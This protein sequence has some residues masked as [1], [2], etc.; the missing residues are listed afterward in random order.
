MK[1]N[2]G[3]QNCSNKYNTHDISLQEIT[4]KT[5]EKNDA[6]TDNAMKNTDLFFVEENC[7]KP[8]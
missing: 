5:Q 7:L 3:R 2:S 4:K 8:R 1:T 6:T